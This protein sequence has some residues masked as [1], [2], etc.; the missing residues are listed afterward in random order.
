MMDGPDPY[1]A[2][3]PATPETPS[4]GP[5]SQEECNFALLAHASGIAGVLG[6]GLLGFVGPLII[7]LLKSE[8]SGYVA[9]QSKEALNFQITLLILAAVC[10][11]ITMISC[12]FLFPIVFVPMILQIV[13]GIIA[14]LA[15]RDGQPYRYPFNIR[16]IR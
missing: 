8:T 2:P 12:G 6:A 13:F 15:A 16:L 5:P 14:A 1:H 10:I 4:V 9:S 3:Q 7:Y 11:G